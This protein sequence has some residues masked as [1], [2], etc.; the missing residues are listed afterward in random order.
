M[1]ELEEPVKVED[2][3]SLSL[4]YPIFRVFLEPDGFGFLSFEDAVGS[5]A[6]PGTFAGCVVAFSP[7]AELDV[8]M[9]LMLDF[10]P[11]IENLGGLFVTACSFAPLADPLRLLS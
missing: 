5:T 6:A 1:E 3:E 11:L 4:A 10:S 8:A 7:L 2:S 9:F